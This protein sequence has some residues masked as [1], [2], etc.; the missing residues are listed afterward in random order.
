M[1]DDLKTIELAREDGKDSR[2][3]WLRLHHDGTI[4]IDGQDMGPLVKRV[5]DHDDYEYSVTVPAAAVQAL[6]FELLRERFTGKLSAV[7][8]LREFCQQHSIPSEFWSWP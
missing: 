1:E 7:T 8:E 5:W 2:V 3:L 6:A 4:S